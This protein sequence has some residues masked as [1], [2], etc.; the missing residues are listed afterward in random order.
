MDC[1]ISAY[2]HDSKRLSIA[3][4]DIDKEN[5]KSRREFNKA[6][7]ETVLR[8]K[9]TNR[10][11]KSRSPATVLFTGNGNHYVIPLCP[12]RQ[13]G[14]NGKEFLQFIEYYLSNGK[15]DEQH[16]KVTSFKNCMLRI[17]SSINSDGGYHVKILHR[18]DGKSKIPLK[19]L[20]E[21]S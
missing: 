14:A 12:V 20:Y 4:I 3:L 2:P 1:R 10:L 8:I 21:K 5:F 6:H 17:P 9:S 7:R 15:C 18:W 16:N 19:S 11:S 13:N